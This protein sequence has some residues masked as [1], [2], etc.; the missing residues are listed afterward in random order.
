M[1]KATYIG[2]GDKARKIKA[3][4]VGDEN[5]K[6]R[7]VTA[8]YVGVDG[9]ARQFFASGGILGEMDV[10]SSVWLNVDGKAREFLVVQQGRPSDDYD[11]SCDG[12]WILMKDCLEERIWSTGSNTYASSSIY[13]YLTGDFLARLDEPVRAM[14]L[15][16]KIPTDLK[17]VACKA[18]LL[19]AKEVERGLNN[20]GGTIYEVVSGLDYFKSGIDK[21]IATFDGEACNWWTRTRVDYGNTFMI[22]GITTRGSVSKFE[23][24]SNNCY[25]RPAMILPKE[26][27]VSENGTII[28]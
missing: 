20:V 14:L 21:F 5:G 24:N 10:G 6:A 7:R 17:N 19:A 3:I 8:G 4:Y 26:T 2:V 13:R 25:M 18:F 15:E 16:A 12:T 1:S 23:S 28:V 22:M 11:A 27:R 9:V